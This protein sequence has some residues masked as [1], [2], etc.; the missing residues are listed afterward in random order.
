MYLKTNKKNKYLHS[1]A[2]S[3]SETIENPT[4]FI[5][6]SRMCVFKQ[7]RE[8]SCRRVLASRDCTETICY[9]RFF[10]TP[11]QH[12]SLLGRIGVNRTR[13]NRAAICR[14]ERIGKL[15]MKYF[16]SCRAERKRTCRIWLG[17]A[18]HIRV[19]PNHTEVQSLFYNKNGYVADAQYI[20]PPCIDLSE[21]LG[22]RHSRPRKQKQN[23]PR[24]MISAARPLT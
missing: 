22:D 19:G 10:R 2:F 14:N 11:P 13:T 3:G 21:I 23:I 4:L 15:G 6:R 12:L 5:Y 16:L 17:A 9:F 24:S 8:R 20:K 1:F 18:L 7:G